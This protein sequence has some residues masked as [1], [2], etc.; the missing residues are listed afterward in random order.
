MAKRVDD[1]AD[2]VRDQHEATGSFTALI[3]LLRIG[4]DGPKPVASSWANVIGD[5]FDWPRMRALLAGAPAQ[6]DGAAF[7]V[8]LM[9]EGGPLPDVVARAKLAEIR[10]RVAADPLHLNDSFLCD[11]EARQIR[12]E[13]RAPGG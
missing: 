11:R 10:A 13:E 6:W 4:P 9:E 2:W 1:F 3:L 5:D 7:F 8:G 12:V